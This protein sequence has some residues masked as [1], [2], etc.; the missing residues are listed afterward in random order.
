MKSVFALIFVM[1]NI[2]VNQV[3]EGKF[4]R[5]FLVEFHF[6]RGNETLTVLFLNITWY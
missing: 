2:V 6:D 5:M 1:Y 3:S 4:L